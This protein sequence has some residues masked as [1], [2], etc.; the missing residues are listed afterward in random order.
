MG[1]IFNDVEFT[2]DFL[3]IISKFQKTMGKLDK[4]GCILTTKKESEF[5]MNRGFY[6]FT[7]ENM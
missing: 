3:D 4:M 6:W 7:K 1:K 2:S 5:K